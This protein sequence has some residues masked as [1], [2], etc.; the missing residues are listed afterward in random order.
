MKLV[1]E[2]LN[3]FR[4]GEDPYKTMGVGVNRPFKEGDK[5]E[6][7]QKIIFVPYKEDSSGG[8]W[9]TEDFFNNMDFLEELDIE[10]AFE[11]IPGEILTLRNVEYGEWVLEP[12]GYY[13]F[14]DWLNDHKDHWKRI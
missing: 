1:D 5:I 14:Y 2:S 11:F 9:M 10:D 13:V 8:E 12:V 6:L 3:E 4:Q 7:L